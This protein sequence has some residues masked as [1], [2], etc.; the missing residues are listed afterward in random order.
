LIS[1]PIHKPIQELDEIE[2]IE[3]KKII[4]KNNNFDRFLKIKKKRI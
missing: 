2:I 3:P 1:N 4:D